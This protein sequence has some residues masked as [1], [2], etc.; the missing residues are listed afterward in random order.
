[1]KDLVEAQIQVCKKY[2]ALYLESPLNFK[3]GISSNVRNTSLPIH[4][5]RHEVINDVS[6]WYIWAGDYKDDPDFFKSLHIFHLKEWNPF[7][8]KYLGLPV[9]WRFLVHNDKYEDV[10]KDE[11][12]NTSLN[13]S[14]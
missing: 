1:M 5:L 6:G 8:L 14:Y 11:N 10:W 2:E 3:I 13:F 12:L 9:G 7:I 4:G